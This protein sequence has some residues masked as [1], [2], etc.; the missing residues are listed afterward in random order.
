MS[1]IPNAMRQ[2][3]ELNRRKGL[4]PKVA[5]DL[6]PEPQYGPQDWPPIPE[7]APT[8]MRDTSMGV[9]P[10]AKGTL[11]QGTRPANFNP[12]TATPTDRALAHNEMVNSSR[13]APST[14]VPRAT[15]Q[16]IPMGGPA[17]R[18]AG[19]ANPEA[20]A[21]KKELLRQRQQVILRALGS[22]NPEERDALIGQRRNLE[23]DIKPLDA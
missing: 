1:G 21:L 3:Y 10:R 15:N 8:M 6:M 9:L 12:D 17:T 22:G 7:N 5:P 11:P 18:T 16:A 2:K 23:A 20:A 13:Y 4:K 19:V 14:N